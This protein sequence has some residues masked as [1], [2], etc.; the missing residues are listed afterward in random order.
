MRSRL[1]EFLEASTEPS[2]IYA[3]EDPVPV[4]ETTEPVVPEVPN[5][6]KKLLSDK[7][8]KVGDFQLDQSMPRDDM[9]K[10][11]RHWNIMAENMRSK[12]PNLGGQRANQ[13]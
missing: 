3:P 2:V 12:Y 4:E 13:L 7:L 8:D 10:Q 9:L 6:N 1:L 5:P 11:K